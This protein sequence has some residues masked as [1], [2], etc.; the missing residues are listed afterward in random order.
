MARGG[1]AGSDV[2]DAVR[3]LAPEIAERADEI[4]EMRRVPADLIEQLT[5][6]GAFRLFTPKRYGGEELDPMTAFRVIEEIARADGSTGWTVMIAADFA[7]VFTLFPKETLDEVYALGP[8]VFARGALAPKGAAVAVDGGYVVQG[9]W[10]LASG[11]FDH[12]W[13]VGNCIVLEDGKP[14]MRPNGVPEMRLVIVEADRAEI[15]K[16][17]DAVGLRAT[18]S[19][20][21]VIGEQFVPERRATDLFAAQ[22]ILDSALYRIPPRVLLGPTHIA[23]AVGIAQ[24]AIDDVAAL[25]KTKRPAFNPMLRL[26]TDPVF[27][28][29]LGWLDTRLAAVRALILDCASQA[30]ERAQAGQPLPAEQILRSKTAV[31]YG[32]AET[33]EIA[34]DAFAIAGSNAVYNSSSLQRRWR[35]ARVAAQHV[36]SSDD[37]Y[38]YLGGFLA[39]EE[40]PPNALS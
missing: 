20:D 34:N 17:W 31:T 36:V 35:D 15:I 10:P 12:R 26:A 32:H 2:V 7:P 33:V 28:H 29:K 18:C 23:V 24:G 37:N 13:A 5:E 25:A 21:I 8:D 1:R 22:S 30:W 6:A 14:R 38:R 3:K 27:Q 16:T 11:S 19:D 40:L 4:D 9:R 39:G